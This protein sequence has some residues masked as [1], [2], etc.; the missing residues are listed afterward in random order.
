M[1]RAS[2]RCRQFARIF[3]TVSPPSNVTVGV[4]LWFR[5]QTALARLERGPLAAGL[6]PVDEQEASRGVERGGVGR[7]GDLE[8]ELLDR[9]VGAVPAIQRPVT[10]P[11]STREQH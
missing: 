8:L 4:D 2:R 7:R 1:S 9:P 10:R 3:I 6:L 5:V 11:A